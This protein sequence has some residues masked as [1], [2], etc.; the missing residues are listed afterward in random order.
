M[1]KNQRDDLY[2]YIYIFFFLISYEDLEIKNY[3]HLVE[4]LM[5]AHYVCTNYSPFLSKGWRNAQMF[6]KKAL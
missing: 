4:G 5:L 6:L 3:E 1:R 2:S